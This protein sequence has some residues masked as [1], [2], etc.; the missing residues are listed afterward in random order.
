MLHHPVEAA[1]PRRWKIKE[2][3]LH[4]ALA[5]R[6]GKSLGKGDRRRREIESE[7]IGALRGKG[8]DIVAGA[9]AGNEH[10][11]ADRMA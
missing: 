1:E 6:A 10:F 9:R 4:V 11:A 7:H 3:A 5:A 2:I 8:P